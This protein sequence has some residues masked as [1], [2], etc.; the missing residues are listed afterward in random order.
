MFKYLF[1]I[2]LLVNTTHAVAVD[3][4]LLEETPK[5][6]IYLDKD[7]L[8][9]KGVMIEYET[10]HYFREPTEFMDDKNRPYLAGG[11]RLEIVTNCTQKKQVVKKMK[12]LSLDRNKIVDVLTLPYSEFQ[13]SPGSFQFLEISKAC[14]L[15]K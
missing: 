2:I 1:L 14:G 11:A 8:R 9:K 7:S 4:I 6:T 10:V 15:I 12:F 3:L 5:K 13:A